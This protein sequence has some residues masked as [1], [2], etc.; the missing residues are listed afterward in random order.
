MTL[1]S[2]FSSAASTNERA[3]ASPHVP[4][5]P[6]RE[7]SRQLAAQEYVEQASSLTVQVVSSTLVRISGTLDLSSRDLL[8][9]VLSEMPADT[10]IVDVRALQF[11]DP[12]GL[13][14][15]TADHLRRRA[16]HGRLILTGCSQLL[17]CML[18]AGNYPMQSVP[19]D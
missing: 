14:A 19:N 18:R 12:A 4:A 7:Q 15:L 5:A 1:T 8:S 9:A 3:A 11:V 13:A 10:I 16:V 17:R 2:S 6:E